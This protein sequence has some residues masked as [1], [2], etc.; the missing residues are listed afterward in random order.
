MSPVRRLRAP[1]REAACIG[2]GVGLPCA[3]RA[4]H[5]GRG[6]REHATRGRVEG[7]MAKCFSRID[8]IR[9]GAVNR[10]S[11]RKSDKSDPT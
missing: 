10:L 7:A 2:G 4:G 3:A 8:A 6:A 1:G 9:Q 11:H 5:A